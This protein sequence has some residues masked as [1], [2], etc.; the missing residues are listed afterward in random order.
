[1]PFDRRLLTVEGHRIYRSA[2]DLKAFIPD[3]LAQP[4]TNADLAD[5]MGEPVWLAEKVTY[6]LR[7]MNALQ[8]VGKRGWALL[9]TT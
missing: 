2:A 5:A 6:C 3:H 9:H 7:K 4:F 1:V 8:V